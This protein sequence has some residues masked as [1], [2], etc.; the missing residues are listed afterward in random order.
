MTINKLVFILSLC[1][2][3][4]ACKKDNQ[5]EDPP[6]IVSYKVKTIKGQATYLKYTYNEEGLLIKV[7][8][9]DRDKSLTCNITYDKEK[10]YLDYNNRTAEEWW[11]V[12]IEVD[13]ISGYIKTI[14]DGM[15]T[16]TFVYDSLRF[17]D[18]VS[19]LVAS[20]YHAGKYEGDSLSYGIQY[21]ESGLLSSCV[22]K[23]ENRRFEYYSGQELESNV[24]TVLVENFWGRFDKIISYLPYTFGP[25]QKFLVK[26]QVTSE[27]FY[28]NFDYEIDEYDRVRKMRSNGVETE[29]IYMD[30]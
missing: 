12:T 9:K 7:D 22:Y 5:Q 3:L 2:C 21:N 23:G 26:T 24:S 29:Y 4:Y 8:G 28:K 16:A 11:Y 1:I 19:R 6:I 30:K 27:S 20:Y 18:K 10:V 14:D 25:P 17:K 13:P 15:Y